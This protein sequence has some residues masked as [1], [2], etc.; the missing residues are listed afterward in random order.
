MIDFSSWFSLELLSP[1]ELGVLYRA[2]GQIELR[3]NRCKS[4]GRIADLTGATVTEKLVR[5][6]SH[7]L[8]RV[9]PHWLLLGCAWGDLRCSLSQGGATI[10]EDTNDLMRVRDDLEELT[11]E[12]QRL[13]QVLQKVARREKRKQ[14]GTFELL[15]DPSLLGYE[16]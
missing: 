9:V 2:R 15:H 8:A 3:F 14:P 1:E 5:L 6:W 16:S 12:L 11:Q 7:L 13:E 4:L 10:R